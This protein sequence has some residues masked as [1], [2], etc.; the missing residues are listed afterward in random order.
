M[1][2]FPRSSKAKG[3]RSPQQRCLDHEALDD[4]MLDKGAEL[5]SRGDVNGCSWMLVMLVMLTLE[6]E[7]FQAQASTIHHNTFCI[8]FSHG[9][10]DFFSCSGAICVF[11]DFEKVI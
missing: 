6:G 8:V 9:D 2:S 11:R 1:Y 4:P 10:Q 5:G 3:Q 7:E